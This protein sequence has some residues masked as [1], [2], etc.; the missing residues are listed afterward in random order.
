MKKIIALFIITLSAPVSAMEKKQKEN[1]DRATI[2][3]QLLLKS[4]ESKELHFTSPCGNGTTALLTKEDTNKN[5]TSHTVSHEWADNF[6][7]WFYLQK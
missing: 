6:I 7:G 5:H 4:T 3:A 1:G 2:A